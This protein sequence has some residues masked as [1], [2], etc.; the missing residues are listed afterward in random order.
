MTARPT[1]IRVAA[2]ALAGIVLAACLLGCTPSA[3]G[4]ATQA[5]TL[6]PTASPAATLSPAPSASALDGDWLLFEWFAGRQVK[7]VLLVR[8]D[9]S[10]RH[11]LATDIARDLG[12][13]DATWSPD[14]QTIAF[15]VGEWYEGTSI[16]EVP[17]DGRGAAQLLGPDARCRLG[18]AFASYSPDGRQLMYVCQ[19][20]TSGTSPDV[21][22]TLEILDL[23]TGGRSS[24]VT[25]RGRQE[26]IEPS[27]SRDGATAVF[28]IDYWSEDLLTQV[29]SAI[30]T[31]PIAGGEISLLTAADV[32]AG[33]PRWSPTADL[34]VYGT[35]G[36]SDKDMTLVSTIRVIGPDGSGARVIWPGTDASIGRLGAARWWPDGDHL[37][38]SIATGTDVIEDIQAGSLTLEGRLEGIA[39]HTSGVRFVPRPMP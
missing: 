39:S 28:T 24:L 36:Y 7:D 37:I 20:G 18:V 32:W 19:D 3:S 34:I 4:P 14:G 38:V 33:D 31:V 26:L 12:H 27:W 2:P 21:H 10:E 15:D 9:G 22:E 6:G 11:V 13:F 8:P 30:A 17:I 16:W 5:A 23:A 1:R 29:G 35:H 25:L